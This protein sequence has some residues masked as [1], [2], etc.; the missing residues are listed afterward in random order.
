MLLEGFF[1][2]LRGD[3]ASPNQPPPQCAVLTGF[4]REG[5]ADDLPLVEEN[6]DGFLILL[7]V[8]DTR[9]LLLPQNLKEVGQP[10]V[11]QRSGQPRIFTALTAFENG[12]SLPWS[13]VAPSG[14][15]RGRKTGGTETR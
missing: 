2:V 1:P 9:L 10:K 8:E 7:E 3:E 5:D 4:L 12:N 11:R 14:I 6:L 15:E 13:E